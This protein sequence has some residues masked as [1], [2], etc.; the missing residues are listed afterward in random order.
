MIWKRIKNW[1]YEVSDTGLVRNIKTSRILK[2]SLHKSGY[3]N[4]Q[5]WKDN[6]PWTVGVHQLVAQSFHGDKPSDHHEV[7]HI[8][9]NRIS[10]YASNLYWGLHGDNMNDRNQHGT[11]AINEKNGKIKHSNDKVKEVLNFVEK[12]NTQKAASIKFNIP[13]ATVHGW[14]SRRTRPQ[15][16]K[17]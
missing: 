3:M 12:G 5:L 7:C 6:K 13:S 10:N 17:E 4:V 16:N 15:Q 9:G 11:T 8:N 2:Q 14:V 1:A